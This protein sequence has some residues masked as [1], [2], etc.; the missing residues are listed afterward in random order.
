MSEEEHILELLIGPQHPASG[1]M[2]LV[3]KVDG[4]VVV[5]LRPDIGYVHRTVE[6]LAETKNYIQ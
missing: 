6:K 4:D 5:S 2:R 1:H 3:A